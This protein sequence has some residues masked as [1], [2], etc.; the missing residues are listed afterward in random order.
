MSPKKA[1]IRQSRARLT[2]R[3]EQRAQL[4]GSQEVRK[5][6]ATVAGGRVVR[7]TMTTDGIEITG[8]PVVYNVAYTVY[9]SLGS[10]QETMLPGVVSEIM[11]TCDC[12]FLVNHS[13]E[14]IPLARTASRTLRLSDGPDALRFSAT[15]DKRQSLAND[16]A[17]AIE[18]GDISQMSV[19]FIVGKDDWSDDY[20]TRT[21]RSI[22][23]LLDVSAVTYPASPTTSIGLTNGNGMTTNS[24]RPPEVFFGVPLYGDA[25]ARSRMRTLVLQSKAGRR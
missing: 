24:A 6:S 7:S 14:M 13:R 19:G 2:G 22:A 11:G 9:D 21:I 5:F 8:A 1:P 23:E 17:V 12:R 3:F 15:L 20:S 25:A 18:R 16:L 10:F 4:R